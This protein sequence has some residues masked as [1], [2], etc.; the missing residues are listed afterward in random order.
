MKVK[1]FNLVADNFIVGSRWIN[2]D[3]FTPY[4]HM[5]GYIQ[6]LD[7][8]GRYFLDNFTFCTHTFRYLAESF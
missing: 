7:S 8:G 1:C 2:L 4:T 5:F 3:N 6:I